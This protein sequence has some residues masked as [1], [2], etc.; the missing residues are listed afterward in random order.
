MLMGDNHVLLVFNHDSYIDFKKGSYIIYKGFKFEIMTDIYPERNKGGWKYNLQFDA[1]DGLLRKYNVFYRKQ[2]I[3]EVAFALT[4]DLLSF[5]NVICDCINHELGGTNWRVK[6]I[7]AEFSEVIKTLSF[8]GEKLFDALTMIAEQFECEWWTEENGEFV[9]ICFGKLSFGTEEE[10]EEG[11]VIRSIPRKAGDDSDFGTRFFVYGSTRNLTSDYGQV[12]QGGTTNHISE[13]RLRLPNGL[14]YIDAWENLAPEDIVHQVAF[15]DDIYPKNTDVIT[16]VETTPRRIEGSDETFNAYII[17]AEN[18][19]F[20]PSDMIEGETLGCVFET[21]PLQGQSFELSINYDPKT[22]KP[23]D[24]FDKKFE[25][26]HVM[27]GDIIVPNKSFKPETGD[28]FVITGVKLPKERIKEAEQELLKAGKAW[29]RKNSMDTSIYECPTN[30]VYCQLNEKNYDLGQK[31]RLV[32]D[33]FGDSGRSSRIQGY[34]KKLWNEFEA[35]YTVGDNSQY[36]RLGTIEGEIKESQY[37]E[38]IGV[39]KGT[40]IYLIR[41]SFDSTQPTN[42]NAYSALASIKKFVP[43]LG[44]VDQPLRTFD[45]VKFK[46][47]LAQIFQTEGFAEGISGFK[48]DELGNIL[49]RSLKLFDFLEVP[50]LRYNKITVVGEEQ[51]WTTGGIIEDILDDGNV[52][53]NKYRIKLKLEEGEVNEFWEG[54]ICKGVFN[55]GT[56]FQSVYFTIVS[57]MD[58][59]NFPAGIMDVVLTGYMVP[60]RKFMTIA[61][62][63]NALYTVDD[64]GKTVP[65]FPARQR[66]GRVSVPRGNLQFFKNVDSWQ[67]T[68][69]NIAIHIG[70]CKD[71]GLPGTPVGLEGNI[72]WADQI[73]TKVGV[74]VFDADGEEVPD[75]V[76]KGEWLQGEKYTKNNR[77][78]YLGCIYLCVAKSTTSQPRYDNPDWF[79][80]S[81]NPYFEMKFESSG[82]TRFV[83]DNI[84]TVITATVFKYNQDITGDISKAQWTWTRASDYPESDQVWNSQHVGFGNHLHLTRADFPGSG[85]RKLTITCTAFIDEVNSVTEIIQVR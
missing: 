56:G 83:N 31:V 58:E 82:G 33:R 12:E 7:P 47:V 23:S 80:E 24:G 61:R 81:G 50:E 39:V 51:W 2:D 11:K 40:G 72:I 69:A 84:D 68:P 63:G 53:D 55:T 13:I 41:D 52:E 22:W 85:V 76:F 60:P 29:A 45:D 78:G 21:G 5:G 66:S 6:A 44:Y 37:S 73:Y 20:L 34:E 54:D 49:A 36:S 79:M 70:E 30:P 19:P 18:T 57:S 62:V 67:L 17:T 25:I 64:Q 8:K 42:Y 77:V 4:T 48:V 74:H 3:S 16:K 59:P 32:G 65:R 15:F 43:F 27:N 10:F 9:D 35:T 28:K 71:A 1:K 14:N 26:I 75:I 38:R 46:S